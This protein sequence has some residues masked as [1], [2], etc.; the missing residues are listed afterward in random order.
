MVLRG[1]KAGQPVLHR[2][3]P[4]RPAKCRPGWPAPHT[5][6]GLVFMTRPA[7]GLARG[8]AGRPAFFFNVEEKTIECCRNI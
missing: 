8:L 7:C 6:C 1:G 3:A 4:L 2:P 5:K